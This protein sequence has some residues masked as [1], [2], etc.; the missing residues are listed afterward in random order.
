MEK[1]PE[2]LFDC[3]VVNFVLFFCTLSSILFLKVGPYIN[4]CTL[5]NSD[6]IHYQQTFVLDVHPFNPRIAM[7]AGY[8]G[9]T[10]IWDVSS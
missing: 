6:H 2:A 7:S 10:I 5:V 8:D 9:K 3:N 4:R 1:A